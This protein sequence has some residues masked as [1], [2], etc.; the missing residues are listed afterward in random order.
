MKFML[1]NP[2]SLVNKI[3]DVMVEVS[4]NNVDFAGI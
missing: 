3:D 2:W 4:D 1:L